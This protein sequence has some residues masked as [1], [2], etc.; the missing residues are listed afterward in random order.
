LS[1][2]QARRSKRLESSVPVQ[3][4]R[5]ERDSPHTGD[6]ERPFLV[7]A[8]SVVSAAAIDGVY[9]AIAVVGIALIAV[10]AFRAQ[11][12]PP[13]Q[14]E[15][16][17]AWRRRVAGVCAAGREVIDLTA[18]GNGVESASGLT[19]DQLSAIESK[20]D[21]LNTRIRDVQATAPTPDDARQMGVAELHA[22][23]LV[24]TVRTMRRVRLTS[25]T[26][27]LEQFETLGLQLAT[28]RSALDD[29]LR[30][31]S[32]GTGETR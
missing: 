31:I 4:S 20:L 13:E 27:A 32:R 19:V 8:G 25:T 6:A 15:Q 9:V 14:A 5:T 29:V 22:S 23:S 18:T 17:N 3:H 7:N 10:A 30:E 1:D 28:H 24:E 12:R 11:R 16:P 21:L 2:E 26:S